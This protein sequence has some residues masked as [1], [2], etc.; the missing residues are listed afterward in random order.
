MFPTLQGE[1][2][3]GKAKI[4]SIRV[5]ERHDGGVIET[6]HGYLGGKIQVNEKVI[7]VGKNIGKKN[8]TTPLQQAESEARASWIKK[9]ESGYSVNEE[10]DGVASATA[11]TDAAPTRGKG[12][13]AEV[14]LPML[15]HEYQKRG[16]GFV[17]PCYVQPKL[18]GTRAVGMPGKGIFSRLRKTFPHMEHILAEMAQL[19]EDLILD[20]EL[21]TNELTFQEIVGLVKKETLKAGDAEKQLKIKYHVYDLIANHPYET[22][23]GMLAALFASHRFQHLVLVPTSRCESEAQMKLQHNA[24]VA[25]G[26]EGIMLRAPSGDYKHSRSA[27]LLKYKEFFDAE[28]EVVGFKE[29]EG[30]EKGCVLWMCRT[31]EGRTFHCRPRGTRESRIELFQ[32]GGDYVGKKLT[33]RY[34]ELTSSEEKVPRFPVGIAFRDY[35]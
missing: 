16:K 25:D 32:N 9:K 11:S 30:Q 33:V 2:T 28:Y 8:E 14:P 18:D 7:A 35:E 15:A 5:F 1:A 4:W 10:Q 27:D 12:I 24:Y 17:F 13:D 20:G 23:K 3:T 31:E 21:Y 34:Q 6:S 22:R 26:F 19:P 29:G